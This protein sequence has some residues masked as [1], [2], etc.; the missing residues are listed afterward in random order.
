[1]SLTQQEYEGLRLIVES[2]SRIDT[3]TRRVSFKVVYDGES[4]TFSEVVTSKKPQVKDFYIDKAFRKLRKSIRDWVKSE[5]QTGGV[6]GRH[7]IYTFEDWNKN[8]D[9]VAE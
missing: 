6:V 9:D 1:M 2:F 7:Y 3:L 8:E 4:M 5:S